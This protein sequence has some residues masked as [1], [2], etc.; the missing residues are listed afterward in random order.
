MATFTDFVERDGCARTVLVLLLITS[1]GCMT[2]TWG[3]YEVHITSVSGLILRPR[4]LTCLSFQGY[5][6]G[7]YSSNLMLIPGNSTTFNSSMH[8]FGH[9]SATQD[10]EALLQAEPDGAEM[11]YTR[12]KPSEESQLV[13]ELDSKKRLRY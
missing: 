12:V 7:T 2:Y 8:H 10:S 1:V 9:A 3:Y 6:N 4:V 11:R 13:V 5:H